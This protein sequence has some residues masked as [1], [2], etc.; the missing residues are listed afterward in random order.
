MGSDTGLTFGLGQT[1]TVRL[2]GAD[3]VT[4]AISLELLELQGQPIAR[5]PRHGRPGKGFKAG[6]GKPG[7]RQPSAEK[8]KAAKVKRKVARTRR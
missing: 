4:G 3:P 7:P 6:R 2:A 5:G 1:V 8:A